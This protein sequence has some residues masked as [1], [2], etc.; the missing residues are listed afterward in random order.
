MVD[1][2]E[3]PK[4]NL[5]S[6]NPS[7]PVMRRTRVACK[8]CNARRVKCDAADGQP[9][10][11][12]RIRQTPCELIDSKRGKYARKRHARAQDV[13]GSGRS[14]ETRDS[15]AGGLT[16]MAPAVMAPDATHKTIQSGQTDSIHRPTALGG[17]DRGSGIEIHRAGIAEINGIERPKNGQEQSHHRTQQL[18]ESVGLSYVVEVVYSPKDGSTEPLKVHY[19]IPASIADRPDANQAPH[20]GE[21]VSLQ[22]AFTMPSPDVADQLVQAFF[23]KLHPAYPVFDRQKFTRQYRQGQASPLVLQTIFFLGFTVGSDELVHAAGYSDRATARKTHY[24]R[25]K[26]LYDVDYENDRMNLVAVLLLFGFWWAGPED[27]KDTCFWIGCATTL[28]QSLGMHRASQSAMSQPMRSLRKRIWWAIYTRD[29]HTSA[30]FGRPCRIRDEDCD[31]EALDEDDFKFDNDYDQTLIPVQTD[32]HI[33][34]ALEMIRLATILGDILIG[35]FSPR[36]AA[37]DKYDTEALAGR[38][39]Q[40]ESKLPGHLRK[41]TPDGSLGASFWASML[42]FSYQNCLILLFRPKAIENLSPAE[43]KCDVRGRMAADTITRLA[44]DLLGAGMIKAGLI[45][46]VPALFSALSVHTIVICRKDP[47][48]RQLAENKSRQCL[49]ALS[50][51]AGSWPVK[52]WIAKA[53]LNLLRRLTVQGSAS[54]VNV[55]SSIANNR[56]NVTLSGRSSSSGLH[57]AHSPKQTVLESSDRNETMTRTG[58]LNG[59]QLRD[60]HPSG[61]FPQAADHFVY[62]SF[63]ASYLDNTFD[64]DLL[65]HNGL[66]P[67][68]AGPFDGLDAAEGANPLQF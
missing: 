16:Q 6:S 24:L 47:I 17:N 28:A 59:P 54:I 58:Y 35:E 11:H 29:R 30:A 7:T 53:F 10:W 48:R 3:S 67:T 18:G 13:H 36:R 50:E 52:I 31:V 61:G 43:A 66:G 68:L 34:Y 12:C 63:W 51:L 26:A 25:A 15:S 60:L 46:L 14:Q 49:L 32:F 45:H 55:S 37:L 44:E 20:V 23:H 57:R 2:G 22:E 21:P 33:S 8:A 27:Q 65:L 64:V 40:W 41:T 19:P 56:S 42:Q 39:A 1:P 38:L 9:C 5:S 62:N 4:G